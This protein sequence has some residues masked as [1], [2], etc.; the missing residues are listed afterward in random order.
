MKTKIYLIIVLL[1]IPI[2]SLANIPI[3]STK[4]TDKKVFTVVLDAG[5]GGKDSGKY[6]AQTAEKDIALKVVQLLG[7]Q[8][9]SHKDIKV[10]YT[11]TTDKFLELYQRADI[12][13]NSK[14]DLFVSVH[15]NAA[16]ATA[17]K[18]NETWV[19]GIHRNAANLEVVQRENS[20]ILLEENYKEKYV[21]FDPND[22]SSFATNLMIQEEYLDNSIE[23]GANVQSRFQKQLNRK[24]RGVKQ[25]G[26]AVL[27]LSYMPSVLIETG[28]LTNK[29]ERT[30]LR[31]SSGQKKVANS[32]YVAVLDY[33]KN[34]D[35]NLFEVEQVGTSEAAPAAAGNNAV[36]KVQISASSNMLEAK[37]YNFKSLPE[38]SRE[39][40][41][42]IYRYFTGNF[43]SLKEVLDLKE[44]AIAK[45]YTSAFI[46]VYENG[47]RRR[48]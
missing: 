36:Y 20:V 45:G 41:G 2:I 38:I 4:V 30:F 11:R 48:L 47:E 28:F 12:A 15:C 25:A 42:G 40:E 29:E 18:G 31:S 27:R 8:L 35:I 24:N 33:Q 39:K 7:K 37:S 5:H 9:E 3:D 43:Y 23:M 22:P 44:K 19:L 14:A 10:V 13:N 21:G 34:R 32:I 1:S 17:A 26:F 46:V 16:A 6:V